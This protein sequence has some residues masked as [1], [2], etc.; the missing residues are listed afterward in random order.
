MT[1]SPSL[2]RAIHV[3]SGRMPYRVP[4]ALTWAA[5][6]ALI[7][8]R[9]SFRRPGMSGGGE[10]VFSSFCMLPT[11]GRFKGAFN[12]P[13]PGCSVDS[14]HPPDRLASAGYRLLRAEWLLRE[15]RSRAPG[16]QRRGRQGAEEIGMAGPVDPDTFQILRALA[17]IDPNAGNAPRATRSS[18]APSAVSR[19]PTRSPSPQKQLNEFAREL[20]CS[21]CGHAPIGA[22]GA[23]CRSRR[24]P[25]CG[26]TQQRKPAQTR[27]WSMR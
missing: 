13:S 27:I 4:P 17:Q 24:H 22:D 26:P 18:A 8:S 5:R 6:S 16:R 11:L 2:V 23:G 21:R 3:P 7:R 1:L 15:G 25:P 20:P 12:T 19:S 10:F 9:Q 14:L